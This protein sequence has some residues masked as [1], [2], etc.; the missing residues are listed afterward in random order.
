MTEFVVTEKGR[1]RAANLANS[2]NLVA[3]V[4]KVRGGFTADEIRETAF[5]EYLELHAGCPC[6]K[7]TPG[8][9]E[10]KAGLIFHSML[11]YRK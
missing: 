7:G 10:E 4:I 2:L 3:T 8:S 9:A 6:C 11:D 5:L 1:E